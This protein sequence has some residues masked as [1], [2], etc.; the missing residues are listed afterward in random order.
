M[1]ILHFSGKFRYQPPLYNNEPWNSEKYFDENISPA[2]VRK[3]I[4][5]GVEPLQY[6]EFEFQDVFVKMV[7]YDDGT[8]NTSEDNDAIINKRIMLKALMVDTSPHLERSRLFA[9]ELRVID[10]MIGKMQEGFESDLFTTI[11]SKKVGSVKKF[12]ADFE[13][14]LYELNNLGGDFL[15]K[16]NSRYFR[17]VSLNGDD[18]NLNKNSNNN[19]KVYFHLCKF[20]YGLLEGEV[21]GYIGPQIPE[22]GQ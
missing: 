18:N 5:E 7:T 17:E 6:F 10:L 19:F 13:S 3:N 1:P 11:R 14:N 21:Y 9:G 16:E 8:S 2:I 22:L 12:S 4:T 15:T 20:D